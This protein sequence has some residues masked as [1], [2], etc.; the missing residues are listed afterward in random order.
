MQ[1]LRLPCWPGA[2]LAQPRRMGCICSTLPCSWPLH[3]GGKRACAVQH[4]RPVA[5]GRGGVSLTGPAACWLP[6]AVPAVQ[7]E[8][9]PAAAAA[10]ASASRVQDPEAEA[11]TKSEPEDEEAEEGTRGCMWRT[12]PTRTAVRV[13]ADLPACAGR[14][15]KSTCFPLA[16]AGQQL[17]RALA[18]CPSARA[19]QPA[20]GLSL[21]CADEEAMS[22]DAAA[23]PTAG[24]ADA[25]GAAEAAGAAPPEQD[26]E[27]PSEELVVQVRP[28]QAAGVKLGSPP[29]LGR[30]GRP[31]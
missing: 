8:E 16:A 29:H 13:S 31:R 19:G 28:C 3:R 27:A 12:R 30:T 10:Q 4:A 2:R 15:C 6:H 26:G 21:C 17:A 11:A 1:H 9:A 24:A 23:E 25:A 5:A 18:G 20:H 14:G 22:E 7:G